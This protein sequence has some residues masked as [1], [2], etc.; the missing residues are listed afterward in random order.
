MD[1]GLTEDQREIQ[2]TARELL[3]E[4][5]KP[6]RVREHAEAARMDT[7][8]W[9]ELCGLDRAVDPVRGAGALIGACP[10]PGKHDGGGGDRARRL[11]RA[12]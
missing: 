11:A 1:F 2:R 4:R 12:A 6:E 7:E 8:L 5:C 10:F 9:A 3:S